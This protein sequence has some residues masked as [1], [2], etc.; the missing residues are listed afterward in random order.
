MRDNTMAALAFPKRSRLLTAADY[1]FVFD[2]VD[3]KQGGSYF[4][5]LARLNNEGVH[6]LGIITAKRNIPKAVERNRIKRLIRESFRQT[7]KTPELIS[8]ANTASVDVIVLAKAGSKER[9]NPDILLA[10]GKQWQKLTAKAA[11]HHAE[12]AL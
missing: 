12:S 3:V 6:R 4:T 2:Q 11:S 1:Q 5:F 7:L 8:L 10:L 9:P